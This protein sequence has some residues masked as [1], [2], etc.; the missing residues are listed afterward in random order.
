VCTQHVGC[1]AAWHHSQ[2]VAQSLCSGGGAGQKWT[3]RVECEVV[4]HALAHQ[5][6]KLAHCHPREQPVSYPAPQSTATPNPNSAGS[7]AR[8]CLRRQTALA[9]SEGHL[10]DFFL[11]IAA[12]PGL[13]C[14]L[15]GDA[16]CVE[17]RASSSIALTGVRCVGWKGHCHRPSKHPAAPTACATSILKVVRPRR[18]CGRSRDPMAMRAC[19]VGATTVAVAPREST[20]RRARCTS[21]TSPAATG[22]ARRRV[23]DATHTRVR[24]CTGACP[25][26]PRGAC[27]GGPDGS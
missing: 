14:A 3:V 9:V 7:A 21:T 6:A 2:C 25:T 17:A 23:A 26:S 16:A 10:R 19:A 12:R 4:A 8:R 24:A 18:D 11:F 1:T 5:A 22:T 27:P 13:I 15:R 20:I